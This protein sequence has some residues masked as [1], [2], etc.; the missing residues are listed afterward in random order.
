MNT[1]IIGVASCIAIMCDCKTWPQSVCKTMGTWLL[2]RVSVVA[3][4]RLAESLS[5]A[6]GIVRSSE[7]TMYQEGGGPCVIVGEI[8][9]H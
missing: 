9:K 4:I 2:A 3:F 1:E 5:T 6:G 8:E 7:A